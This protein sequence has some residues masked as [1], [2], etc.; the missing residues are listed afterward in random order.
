LRAIFLHVRQG[1]EAEAAEEIKDHLRIAGIEPHLLDAKADTAYVIAHV[2]AEAWQDARKKIDLAKLI[3]ARQLLWQVASVT[4]PLEGDR[5]SAIISAVQEH[6]LPASGGNAFS[7]FNFETPDTDSAKELSG[8]CKALARPVENSLNRL[9]ILPKGKGAAHLPRI[10]LVMINNQQVLISLS[11]IHNS[12]P[13]P[14][15]IPRLK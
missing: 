5:A 9:K 14:M 1:F 3:F 8:F 4:L 12:S 11:D 10:S 13:W 15:G 7:A 6:L 2:S